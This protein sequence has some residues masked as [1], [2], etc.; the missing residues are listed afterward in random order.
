MLILVQF[1]YT[2]PAMIF[3]MGNSLPRR[4]EA[5]KED[6]MVTRKLGNMAPDFSL[7]NLAGTER[8][9]LPDFRGNKPVSLIFGN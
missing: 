5:G 9:T 2:V 4:R 3:R 6:S 7:Q 1:R 8:I